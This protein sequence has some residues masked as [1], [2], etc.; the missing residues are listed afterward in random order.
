MTS[1][2]TRVMIALAGLLVLAAPA[3]AQ[4][5]GRRYYPEREGAF[6]IHLGAFQPDGD[7]EYWRDNEADFTGDISDFEDA[8]FGLDYLLP[9]NDRVSLIFSGSIYEGQTTSAYRNFLDNFNDRIRH[10]TT[11]DI[12][13]G[14]VGLVLHLTGP[15]STVQPYVGAG[16]GA[17][18]WELEESGDFIDL[19]PPSHPI[20]TAN[21][22]SDGVAFGYYGLVGLEAPI[23][24]RVS[25]FAEGRW[26]QVEDDLSGD[27]EGLGKL[28]LSGRE[29]AAGLSWSL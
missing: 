26:T 24:R 4:R 21:L 19:G 8:S 7:S 25:I 11:L 9:L 5:H 3:F 27:L 23:T 17:Y 28:D 14:T 13:S 1:G 22:K 16:V 6:R 20:F 2:K 29:V 15:G 10:D 18:P 12:A